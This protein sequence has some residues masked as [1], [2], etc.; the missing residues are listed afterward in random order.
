MTKASTQIFKTALTDLGDATEQT[1]LGDDVRLNCQPISLDTPFKAAEAASGALAAAGSVANRIA[2]LRG[3][4]R[5]E[6]SVASRHAEHSLLSFL[7]LRFKDPDRAPA[8]RLEP[9]K[10]TA[11]AG[12]FRTSDDRWVYLHPGFP[13]NT[14]GLL[15][16]L[17]TKDIRD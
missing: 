6:V 10:R 8:M 11:A 2:E 1:T 16:L 7:Y 12:F 15:N 14:E 13:H 5:G 9:E 4:S 17:G 3:H